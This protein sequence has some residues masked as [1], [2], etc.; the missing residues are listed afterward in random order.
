MDTV[1]ALAQGTKGLLGETKQPAGTGTE[2]AEHS[3]P[4]IVVQKKHDHGLGV[5]NVKA[6]HHSQAAATL[7]GL[8]DAHD[9]DVERSGLEAL[10]DGG[11]IESTSGNA[12]FR[13]SPQSPSEKLAPGLV[14]IGHQNGE[15]VRDGGAHNS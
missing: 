14:G 4:V 10:G 13:A 11:Q 12:K 1:N 5:G 2:S 6:P 8:V 7:L 15:R 9:R 3:L